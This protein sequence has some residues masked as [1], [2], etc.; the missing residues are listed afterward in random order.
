M[1]GAISGDADGDALSTLPLLIGPAAEE[2][3]SFAAL[4]ATVAA[5]LDWDAAAAGAAAS[6]VAVAAATVPRSAALAAFATVLSPIEASTL[7]VTGSGPGSKP[8]FATVVATATAAP[9]AGAGDTAGGAAPAEGANGING[10]PPKPKA[11]ASLG[12]NGGGGLPLG[13]T[14]VPGALGADEAF[15]AVV[16]RPADLPAALSSAAKSFDLGV[17]V[18]L[19]GPEGPAEGSIWGWGD[20]GTAGKLAVMNP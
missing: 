4:G 16:R 15:P 6:A 12:G 3:P 10:E 17:S 11:R 14:I 7:V 2:A 13:G 20:A 18:V 19:I 1:P 8:P 5:D 9:V